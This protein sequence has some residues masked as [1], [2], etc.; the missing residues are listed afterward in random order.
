M[1]FEIFEMGEVEKKKSVYSFRLND[2]F[3]VSVRMRNYFKNIFLKEEVGEA[4][5]DEEFPTLNISSQEII[6]GIE[7]SMNNSIVPN[8]ETTSQSVKPE[9]EKKKSKQDRN[10]RLASVEQNVERFAKFGLF[11]TSAANDVGKEKSR[12]IDLGT[13]VS[14]NGQTIER[15]IIIV[16]SALYGYPTVGALELLEAFQYLYSQSENQCGVVEIESLRGFIKNILGRKYSAHE[17]VAFHQHLAELRYT[18][19][20]FKQC[21]YN[22]DDDSTVEEMK[23]FNL[24]VESDIRKKNQQNKYTSEKSRVVFNPL[25][26]SNF[27]LGYTK[28]FYIDTA[29][30]IRSEIGKLLYR[31]LCFHFSHYDKFNYSTKKIFEQLNL[32]GEDYVYPS[33]RKR[34]LERAIKQIVNQPISLSKMATSYEFQ[35]SVD[36]SDWNLIVL[37]T[38]TAYKLEQ[39]SKQPSEARSEPLEVRPTPKPKKNPKPVKTQNTASEKQSPTGTPTEIFITSFCAKFPN[40]KPERNSSQK[41]KK[42]VDEFLE[43]HGLE[44]AE[45]F[46]GFCFEVGQ[47]QEFSEV[48]KGQ[49]VNYL[50]DFK[51]GDQHLIDA[52]LIDR[53]RKKIQAEQNTQKV[54]HQKFDQYE[55]LRRKYR[56]EYQ[57]TYIKPIHGELDHETLARFAEYTNQVID[58]RVASYPNGFSREMAK[59]HFLK[60]AD[61]FVK[62]FIDF[63]EIDLGGTVLTLDQWIIAFKSEEESA[64]YFQAKSEFEAVEAE[65]KAV[66]NS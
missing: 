40:A 32:K 20:Q 45:D 25:I 37:S 27:V 55:D 34:L 41:V 22:K 5:T 65:A 19:I 6:H 39:S 11:C 13:E 35:K 15:K 24:I 50:F 62:R 16:P 64:E 8:E 66:A 7:N 61:E 28:P 58:E 23:D 56:E 38:K 47:R 18:A 9:N 30:K 17:V 52:W 59:T 21:F 57:Q 3:K 49:T 26:L 2:L 1:S 42:R 60:S 46:L 54:K 63:Y 51:A 33:V 29:F 10:G 44:Q 31:M 12:T 36:N 43:K 48:L 4:R 14:A 53:G